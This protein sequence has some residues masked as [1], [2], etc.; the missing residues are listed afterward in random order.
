MEKFKRLI[1]VKSVAG[2]LAASAILL[3][4]HAMAAPEPTPGQARQVE[5]ACGT[6]MGLSPSTAEYAACA[7]SLAQSLDA[8]A[9]VLGI[10]TGFDFV[11]PELF[12][13]GFGT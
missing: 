5:R 8:F 2:S 11:D 10:Y 12:G 7:D 9:L 6:I 13:H 1:A 4:T 3:A